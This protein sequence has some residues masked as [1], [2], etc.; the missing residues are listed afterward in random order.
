VTRDC[1]PA[2]RHWRDLVSTILIEHLLIQ[3]LVLDP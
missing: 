1:C 3:G 2:F